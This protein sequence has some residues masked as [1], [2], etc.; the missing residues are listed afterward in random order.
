MALQLVKNNRQK[1]G[2]NMN[3]PLCFKSIAELAA[4]IR[5]RAVSPVEVVEAFLMRIRALDNKVNAFITLTGELALNQ[6]KAAE[7]EITAGRYRG[8]LHGIPIGLKDIYN[9]AGILTSG[10][11]RIG[12]NNVPAVDS[13]VTANLYRAGAVLMGKLATHEFAH[14]GPSFDLPWPPARNPWNLAH[15]SGGSS[16]G[17]G[18]AVAAAFIPGAMGTDT[19]GSIR[20]PAALCGIAGLKPT[21]GRISRAGV[22][23]NSFTF[24]HCGPMTWTVED[25][26]ILLQAT[27][28][29]DPLDPTSS[30]EAVPDYR[31]AMQGGLHGLRI[32]VLRHLWQK[33]LHIDD[34]LSRATES[35]LEVF[36]KLGA[37]LEDVCIR[38]SQE[39]HDVKTVISL[40]ELFSVYRPELICRADQFGEDFL[41][42]GGLAGCLFQAADY[43]CAQQLR[44]KMLEEAELL[45]EKYDVLVTAGAGPAP[46]M[47]AHRT[48]SF[49]EKPTMFSP[50]SVLGNPALIVCCGFTE[51]GLPMGLQIAG[52]PFDESVVL[53][54]GHA[55]EQATQWR[56]RRPALDPMVSRPDI[57]ISPPVPCGPEV[58]GKIRDAVWQAAR[59]SGL[60]LDE[61]QFSH[62][63]R[64]APYALA[65]SERLRNTPVK[66][67]EPAATFQ[68]GRNHSFGER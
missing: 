17:P 25:C 68:F 12:I 46:R 48:V 24:D 40:S 67:L 18:V 66:A 26:A 65:M 37:R 3:N 9:T 33:D 29:Y 2:S 58:S 32:G 35:A 22:L 63:L 57:Q 6:A 59:L 8:P 23:P 44:R 27:A 47:E 61:S 38:P 28:G 31:L 42:R 7:T 30:A 34:H 55:F 11:S 20:A 39:Y 50:F 49:W 16:S 21:Y 4:L 1:F 62:L 53:R 64:A 45:Y 14:G 41:G 51:S 36:S 56:S 43:V 60:K 10:H 5:T 13:T 52:R 54:V 15:F 19:G